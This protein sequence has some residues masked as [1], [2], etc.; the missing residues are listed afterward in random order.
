MWSRQE[1]I[2]ISVLKYLPTLHS[3]RQPKNYGKGCKKN[4][5]V[6]DFRGFR[7]G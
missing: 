1:L 4:F 2:W 6:F 3:P 7:H 5:I